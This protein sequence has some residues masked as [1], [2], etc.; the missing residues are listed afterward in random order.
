MDKS[1]SSAIIFIF[2]PKSA[3]NNDE[4]IS[5]RKVKIKGCIF[6][7][8]SKIDAATVIFGDYR[9]KIAR[10]GRAGRPA[11]SGFKMNSI[12]VYL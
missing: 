5:Y 3:Q 6:S 7:M 4:N 9:A 12:R 1:T 2:L 8:G 11:S 10:V